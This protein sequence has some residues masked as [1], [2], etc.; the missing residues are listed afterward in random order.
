MLV[1]K[2]VMNLP[3]I[4]INQRTLRVELVTQCPSERWAA[5]Q[6]RLGLSPGSSPFE[7]SCMK[8]SLETAGKYSE[9]CGL[10]SMLPITF[11]S[12]TNFRLLSCA[13]TVIYKNLCLPTFLL[14]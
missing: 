4:F 7:Q 11:L 1:H 2:N 6:R 3:S 5:P 12:A 10:K 13:F 9:I 14:R 8:C